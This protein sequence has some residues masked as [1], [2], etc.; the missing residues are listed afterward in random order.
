[1][2][3]LLYTDI[4]RD[5]NG[6]QQYKPISNEQKKVINNMVLLDELPYEFTRVIVTPLATTY[7]KSKS[8]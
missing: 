2:S 7:Y 3:I 6:N 5:N 1:M 4:R 8:I